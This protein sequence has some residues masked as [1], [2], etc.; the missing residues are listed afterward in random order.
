MTVEGGSNDWGPLRNLVHD[1]QILVTP[2][3]RRK[4]LR[5]RASC[6]SWDEV[7]DDLSA[8]FR[9]LLITCTEILRGIYEGDISDTDCDTSLAYVQASLHTAASSLDLLPA[10]LHVFT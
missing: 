5:N 2:E 6:S 10:S 4:G 9:H 1:L 7:W 8:E 3:Y